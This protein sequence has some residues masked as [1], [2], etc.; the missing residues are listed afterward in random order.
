MAEGEVLEGAEG[1][2]DRRPPDPHQL[3]SGALVDAV[4]C[5]VVHVAAQHA[6]R[7]TGAARLHGTVPAVAGLGL[8]EDGAVFAMQLLAF[9]GLARRTEI[10]VTAG[11]V[12]E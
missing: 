11:L 7:R 5:V 12:E 10:A 8:I 1:M 4:E 2:F 9:H 6:L 3:R